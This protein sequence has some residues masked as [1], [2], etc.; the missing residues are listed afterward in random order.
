[1]DLYFDV[2]YPD[3]TSIGAADTEAL[4]EEL[5]PLLLPTLTGALGE[6]PIPDIQGFTVTG[7]TVDSEGPE[8]GY[9]TLGGD[10]TER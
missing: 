6:V 3:A 10:L 9:I 1:M 8:D 2:V 7:V 5:V 4:L